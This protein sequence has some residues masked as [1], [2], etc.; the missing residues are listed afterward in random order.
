MGYREMPIQV[1]AVDVMA[2]GGG[3]AGPASILLEMQLI[4]I[5]TISPKCI[6]STLRCL[7]ACSA[8]VKHEKSMQLIVGLNPA[9]TFF[10]LILKIS[11]YQYVPVC[12]SMYQYVLN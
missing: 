6:M 3:A 4:Y 1:R 9:C 2:G 7:Y 11:T 8:A 10:V 12:T 5:N